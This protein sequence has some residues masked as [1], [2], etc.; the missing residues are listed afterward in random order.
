MNSPPYLLDSLRMV[1]FDLSFSRSFAP[2]YTMSLCS[3]MSRID[4]TLVHCKGYAFLP[5]L[6]STSYS[7]LDDE[8]SS[9]A[10]IQSIGSRVYRIFLNYKFWVVNLTIIM[11]GRDVVFKSVKLTENRVALR[12]FVIKFSLMDVRNVSFETDRLFK[13][14]V[15]LR[16][17]T[18]VVTFSLM[19]SR[20]VDFET[21]KPSERFF[22]L[23]TF[24]ITLSL[25]DVRDMSVETTNFSES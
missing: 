6:T 5:R 8:L 11:D 24:V 18:F 7:L 10:M 20:D 25:M 19:D 23:W 12:T 15:T 4:L 16:L 17:R 1:L 14:F 9:A 2:W 3:L 22:T 13:S 21:V